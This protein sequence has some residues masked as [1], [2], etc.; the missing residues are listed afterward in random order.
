MSKAN[1][2]T[3]ID[4]MQLQRKDRLT[5]IQNDR[6]RLYIAMTKLSVIIEDDDNV[7]QSILNKIE[8]VISEATNLL[9]SQSSYD[10]ERDMVKSLISAL[11]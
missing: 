1:L 8:D 7:E 10:K 6:A 2:L 9:R 4:S 3:T 5:D 11:K